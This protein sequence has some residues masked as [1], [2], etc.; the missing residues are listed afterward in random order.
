MDPKHLWEASIVY[1]GVQRAREELINILINGGKETH[2]TE[3]KHQLLLS[4][5]ECSERTV[6]DSKSIEQE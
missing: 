5:Q 6:L 2:M 1:Q 4:A 3:R